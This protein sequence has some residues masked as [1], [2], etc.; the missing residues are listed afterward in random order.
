[1]GRL[2]IEGTEGAEIAIGGKMIG[3]LPLAAPLHLDDGPVHIHAEAPGRQSADKDV[4]VASGEEVVA[5]MELNPRP[6]PAVAAGLPPAPVTMAVPVESQRGRKWL[7]AGLVV[8]G[9]AAIATGIVW[10]GIDNKGTCDAA[11]HGTCQHLYDTSLQ[12]WL[13]LGA[14]VALAGTGTGLLLW[15]GH[16]QEVGVAVGPSSIL[17]AGRF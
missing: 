11:P 16:H 14:G 17:A 6:L 7:G 15:R 10:L 4:V 13:A 2:R 3:R 8:G 12:G 9:V 1:M 5:K